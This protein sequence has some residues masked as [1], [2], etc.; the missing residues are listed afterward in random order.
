[1]AAGRLAA[2]A[3][4]RVEV[5]A[6]RRRPAGAG[7]AVAA[8]TAGSAPAPASSGDP[9]ASAA[10]DTAVAAAA[11]RPDNTAPADADGIGPAGRDAPTE[12]VEP[13]VADR[14][15]APLASRPIKRIGA[16]AAGQVPESKPLLT[17]VDGSRPRRLSRT[18][19]APS[20]PA[21]WAIRLAAVLLLLAIA[22]VLI[23]L[24]SR[25]A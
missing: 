1:M 2:G 17:P 11:D 8:D 10:G 22:V 18:R 5:H 15:G 20:A 23:I 4:V 13:D 12:A 16:A 19:R 21:R 25:V 6:A 3:L 7:P 14:R 9:A 24:V